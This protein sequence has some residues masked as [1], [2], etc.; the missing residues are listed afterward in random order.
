MADAPFSASEAWFS[1]SG[2]NTSSSL[3]A[4]SPCGTRYSSQSP[5]RFPPLM[6]PYRSFLRYIAVRSF[7]NASSSFSGTPTPIVT[8]LVF[9]LP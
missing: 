5:K 7:A 1:S 4:S 2:L 3:D 6:S 8:P 9:D